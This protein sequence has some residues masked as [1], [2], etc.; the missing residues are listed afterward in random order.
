MH[1]HLFVLLYKFKYRHR[2]SVLLVLSIKRKFCENSGGHTL[3]MSITGCLAV[4]S[5]FIDQFE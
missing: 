5:T 1:V 3:H 4:R 2:S